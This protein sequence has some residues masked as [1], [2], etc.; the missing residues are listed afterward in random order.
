MHPSAFTPARADV[1]ARLAC[2]A[3]M[4][5]SGIPSS[6]GA[7][8]GDT[9]AEQRLGEQ[10]PADLRDLLSQCDGV[11]DVEAHS[12]LVWP[13]E[14]IVEII[15][16]MLTHSSYR[17]TYMSFER[18]LFLAKLATATCSASAAEA[19]VATSMPG[20]MKTTVFNGSLRDYADISAGGWAEPSCSDLG[21]RA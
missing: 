15:T 3:T 5:P 17:E 19:V 7:R 20:T 21:Q 8:T 10:S 12:C 14:R 1:V 4:G 9:E 16:E 2:G 6:A 11:D 13:V 18:L